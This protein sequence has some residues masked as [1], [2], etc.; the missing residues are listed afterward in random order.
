MNASLS[1][2]PE[3]TTAT[4]MLNP[5]SGLFNY[6]YCYCGALAQRVRE[7]E[8]EMEEAAIE[9]RQKDR[10]EKEGGVFYE[11]QHYR[12]NMYVASG[13]ISTV[14]LSSALPCCDCLS[15]TQPSLLLN[16]CLSVFCCYIWSFFFT[17]S[18]FSSSLPLLFSVY[19]THR[20]LFSPSLW[21]YDVIALSHRPILLH[22]NSF[23]LQKWSQC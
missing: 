22:G 14:S 6:S 9:E 20:S 8:G 2:S 10:A 23:W 7:R 3:D 5:V 1:A 16:F 12:W 11:T 15:Q 21:L 18:N 4:E 19:F 13:S 17:S